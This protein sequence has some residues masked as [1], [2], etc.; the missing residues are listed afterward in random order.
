MTLILLTGSSS[1]AESAPPLSIYAG[2]PLCSLITM[3]DKS[4]IIY[5]RVMLLHLLFTF[6]L[7]LLD[8][9]NILY[10]SVFFTE[11]LIDVGSS[12]SVCV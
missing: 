10:V 11:M 3:P 8:H 6:K 4:L 1:Y 7:R 9:K 2:D 5:F 12:K